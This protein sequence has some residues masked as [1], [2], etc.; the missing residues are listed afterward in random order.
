MAGVGKKG[1]IYM[2]FDSNEKLHAIGKME[3]VD[4]FG[5]NI[6]TDPIDIQ[7]ANKR[8][9]VKSKFAAKLDKEFEVEGSVIVKLEKGGSF[10]YIPGFVEKIE[11]APSAGTPGKYTIGIARDSRITEVNEENIA[12]NVPL[13]IN[14]EGWFFSDTVLGSL[15]DGNQS[16][17]YTDYANKAGEI[18][19]KVDGARKIT[20]TALAKSDP[21]KPEDSYT[22]D[23]I[24][25]AGND[26]TEVKMKSVVP[27]I[28]NTPA[29]AGVLSDPA[30]NHVVMTTDASQ[31]IFG[32]KKSRKQKTRKNTM[33]LQFATGAKRAYLKRRKSSRK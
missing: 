12:K 22:I 30:K 9:T 27:F 6:I 18:I 8:K 25:L 13:G 31:I 15:L 14:E 7:D 24:N 3:D 2:V 26:I 20:A 32:G 10:L 17:S 28:Y 5:P 29:D 4:I 16:I 19:T 23:P 11:Q 1:D 21:T 33:P